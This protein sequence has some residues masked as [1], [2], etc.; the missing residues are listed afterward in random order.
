MDAFVIDRIRAVGRDPSLVDE[1][2]AAA[3]EQMKAR[4]PEL[5]K[6]LKRI[7]KEVGKLDKKR[8]NLL[9]A[10]EKG[11]ATTSVGKRLRELEDTI[12]DLAA[13]SEEIR[14][15]LAA[16]ETEAIDE[17]DLKKALADFDAVWSEL[18]LKERAR[19]V[20]LLVEEVVYD[21]QT[22]E[23]AISFKS[24][25]IKSLAQDDKRESA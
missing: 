24:S 12:R 14:S 6:E 2:I 19:V 21:S 20:A 13:K 23:I 10:I 15:E 7:A 5:T 4:K 18:T 9:A 17:E 3:R 22:D 16:I 1:T 25:G 11:N 8:D